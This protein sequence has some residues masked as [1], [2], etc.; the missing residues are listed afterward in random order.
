MTN[1]WTSESQLPS[2]TIERSVTLLEKLYLTSEER[3]YLSYATC[4]L[5][6]RTSHSPDYNRVMFEQPLSD[7]D[8]K[9]SLQ[10]IKF[11]KCLHHV[12]WF[13]CLMLNHFA[14]KCSGIAIGIIMETETC[15]NA[16]PVC[17]DSA[18]A[19]RNGDTASNKSCRKK[20]EGNAASSRFHCLS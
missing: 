4:L 12:W 5:L 14:W 17:N 11:T 3:D 7:C 20:S 9:V 15:N 8:F 6:E 13:L 2:S 1:F 18:I 19:R 16:T 10:Q